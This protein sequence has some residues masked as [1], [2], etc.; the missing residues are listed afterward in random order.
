MKRREFIVLLGGIAAAPLAAPCAARAQKHRRKIPRIGIIDDA[1]IWNPF[2]DAMQAAGYVEG[3]T[4]AYEYR[5]A[6]GQPDRLAAAATELAALPVDLIA[7]YGTPATRAAKA[8]TTTIPIVMISAGDPVG[9]GLVQNLARPGGNVTGN[10]ILSPDLGPK[11]LQL[12]KEFIP[13]AARVA[14][15]WNPDNASSVAL[16]EQTRASAPGLGLAVLA[17][18]ARNAFDLDGAF[19][20]LG[21]E[22]PDAVLVTNDP[23]HQANVRTIIDLLARHKLPG[24][25]QSRDNA[26]AGGLMS[27]GA[28]FPDLFRGGAAYV[29]KILKGTRPADLPVQ[30]PEHFE[31]VINLKTATA[32]GLKIP[33]PFLMRADEVIE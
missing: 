29:E 14:L 18:E 2:R 25:F 22:R 16:L 24:M 19:T 21:R 1:P 23:V 10:T 26:D 7:T 33:E 6:G 31:L 13:S 11:R 8:A 3:K 5:T 15:I 20:L 28:S 4:V 9:T 12:I 17:V 27:Y 30:P 32:I